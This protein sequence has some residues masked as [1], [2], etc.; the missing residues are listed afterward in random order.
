MVDPFLFSLFSVGRF[1]SFH[2][3]RATCS[4]FFQPEGCPSLSLLVF[5]ECVLGEVSLREQF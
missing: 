3:L 4:L 2:N 5:M 1:S